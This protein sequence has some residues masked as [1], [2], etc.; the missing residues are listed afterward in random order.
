[1]TAQSKEEIMKRAQELLQ[2]FDG[3]ITT[4]DWEVGVDFC[5]ILTNRNIINYYQVATEADIDAMSSVPEMLALIK[6]LL[7]IVD[8]QAANAKWVDETI[9]AGIV[10]QREEL[11]EE[12]QELKHRI[13]ELEE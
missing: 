6:R 9:I 2:E 4:G 5:G 3:K 12:N 11:R 10:K 7:I 1:M 8:K 13:A